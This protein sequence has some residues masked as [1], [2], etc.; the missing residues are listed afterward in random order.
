MFLRVNLDRFDVHIRDQA[1]FKATEARYN[2]TTAE[3]LS[4]MIDMSAR[5][6]ASH[7]PSIRTPE[8]R[9]IN[10]HS[11]RENISPNM[12][13]KKVFERNSIKDLFGSDTSQSGL[14]AEVIALLSCS[15][16]IASR[17]SRF[18]GPSSSSELG[19][20]H[21]VGAGG[22]RTPS[23][24]VV[25]FDNIAKVLRGQLLRDV[26]ESQFGTAGA[27]VMTLLQEK[28]KLEEK[29]V[30]GCSKFFEILL[31]ALC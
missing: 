13:L 16:N 4:S 21:T 23:N 17:G 28:G 22:S 8:S 9:I 14:L 3:V 15:D 20:G 5:L 10:V 18:V 26:V 31:K 25:Q 19:T 11:L 27:R 1:I 7:A 24:S 12:P 2:T 30:S 6:D 29:H